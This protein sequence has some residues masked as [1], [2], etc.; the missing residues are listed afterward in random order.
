MQ[1]LFWLHSAAQLHLVPKHVHAVGLRSP[2]VSRQQSASLPQTPPTGAKQAALLAQKRATL[3]AR[4]PSVSGAQQPLRQ[5]E[6]LAHAAVQTVPTPVSRTQR[7]VL[8]RSGQQS[9]STRQ[10]DP[11]AAK[12]ADAQVPAGEHDCPA[13]QAPHEPVPQL[14]GPQLRPAQVGVQVGVQV[15]RAESHARPDAHVPQVPPQ[16]SAPHERPAQFGVQHCPDIALHEP[17]E[18]QVPQAP[19]Q[20]SGP[21]VRPLHCGV[22][23]VIEHIPERQVWPARQAPQ[24]PPQPSSPQLRPL[25]LGRQVASSDAGG[26][27]SAVGQPSQVPKPEPNSLQV[28]TPIAPPG[29]R[30]AC[31]T[32]GVHPVLV[33]PP[34]LQPAANHDAT[35]ARTVHARDAG[36]PKRFITHPPSR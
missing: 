2:A 4:V 10:A 25:Q 11:T 26:P 12:H 30:Q 24:V 18:G 20:P 17:P 6:L 33:P 29:H 31:V 28:C 9:A 36:I 13:R 22:Q 16:P 34:A 19:P 27:A 15:P 23:A 3:Q 8:P 35:Q 14:F 21:H 32:P 7:V 1:S 5:S